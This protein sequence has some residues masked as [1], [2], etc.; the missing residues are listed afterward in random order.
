VNSILYA[1]A[2]K[3]ERFCIRVRNPEN[4]PLENDL[5]ETILLPALLASGK[6]P[7]SIAASQAKA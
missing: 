4:D 7:H 1:A 3:Q 2:Q 5:A 6:G